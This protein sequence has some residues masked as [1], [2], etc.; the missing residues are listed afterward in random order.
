M[1]ATN[2]PNPKEPAGHGGK[3][4]SPDALPVEP[5]EGPQTQPLPAD[6]GRERELEP[7]Y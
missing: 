6:V 1:P 2:T 5:D 4:L 7:Q 3:P